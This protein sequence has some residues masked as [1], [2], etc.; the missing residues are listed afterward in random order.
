MENRRK[1]SCEIIGSCGFAR[2]HGTQEIEL[3]YRFARKHWGKGYATEITKA[4]LQ[5]GFQKL[6]FS[7]IIAMTDP[8]N[9][10]SQKILNKIGFTKRGL[11]LYNG[12]KNLV[13]LAKKSS[14]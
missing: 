9:L 3:G 2:P 8:Q 11:E 4:A 13:Y 1:S 12:E 7:E 14:Q 5:Y 6:G 10:A